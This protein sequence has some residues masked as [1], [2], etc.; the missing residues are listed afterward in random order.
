MR[1]PGEPIYLRKHLLALALTVVASVTVPYAYEL[2]MGPLS[3]EG[4]YLFGM[5]I[6]VLGAAVL[7]AIFR[8]TAVNEPE[9]R[10]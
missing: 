1:K 4:R 3:L 5:A 9:R 7:L 8:R 2:L 6:A 10:E